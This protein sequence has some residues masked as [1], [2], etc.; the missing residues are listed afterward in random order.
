MKDLKDK[1]AIVTGAGSGIGRGTAL[2]LADAGMNVVVADIDE[3]SASAVAKEVEA[4]GGRGL[5]VRTDVADRSSVEAL[6]EAA[7]SAFG[8][9]HVLHNNAGVALFMRLDSM[10]DIDWRWI[11]S[12]NLEGVINGLQAFLP[13][14]KAQEGEKHIVNTASMAGM[15]APQMLGAYNATKFAVVAISETLREEVATDGIGVSV[16]C[17]GVVGTNIMQNSLRDR[18][19]GGGN[20]QLPS[21]DG[22]ASFG[23]VVDPSDVGR[24]VR[25]AIIDNEPYIFT[26]PEYAAIASAR[27]ERI[28]AAFERAGQRTNA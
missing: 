19:A 21:I 10:E 5:A 2:A 18:P 11:L 1:V 28:L 23:R 7:Y 9:V 4:A 17:P 20:M 26:H 25:Q 22:S 27:F 6:A 12:I 8:S 3:A 14:M 13:R 16:L 24:L 15:F